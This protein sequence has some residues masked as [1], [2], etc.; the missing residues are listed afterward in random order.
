MFPPWLIPKPKVDFRIMELNKGF[1]ESEIG[2]MGLKANEY[3]DS[4]AKRSSGKKQI[5]D[6]PSGKGNNQKE[7]IGTLAEEV[8]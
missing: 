2:H 4:A 5:M 8:G 6:I 1:V 7:N 3:A